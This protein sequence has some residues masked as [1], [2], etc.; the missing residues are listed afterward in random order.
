MHNIWVLLKRELAGYFSTPVAYVFIV[1]F[2]LMNGIF[3][4]YFGNFFARGQADLVPF[5][6]FHPWI[7][8]V[9][10]P[11]ITMRLW[12]EERRM[13]TIELLFTLPVTPAQAVISKFLAAWLFATVALFLTFPVWISVN[14][15]GNP[16]NGVIAASYLG[17]VLLAGGFLVIGASISTIT[18]NQVVAF[19]VSVMLCLMCNLIGFPIVID[20]ISSWLPT[21]LVDT[22]QSFSFLSNFE[23]LS[24]GLID[25]KNI[26]FFLSFITFGL[27]ANTVLIELNKAE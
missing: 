1:I 21:M 16:D 15:L 17:S 3:T 10:I 9:F 14:Y 18:K 7:Y 26:V 25:V 2:L 22:I 24:K 11:A 6:N 5:F 13:G 4:F 8:M 20:Y 23:G 12:A 27:F 19:V